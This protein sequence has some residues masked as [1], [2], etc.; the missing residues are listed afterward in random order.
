MAA[1]ISPPGSAF[2]AAPMPWNTSM[3]MP[4]VR[5]RSPLKSS[6]PVTGFLNQPS[7]CVG[8]G[9]YTYETTLAPI[10]A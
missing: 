10:E 1:T 2:T 9:P 8:I 6:T 5:N 3:E 7:G 4:T